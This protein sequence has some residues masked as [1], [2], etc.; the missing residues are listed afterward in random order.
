MGKGINIKLS[1]VVVG[2][3]E[4]TMNLEYK[5]TT[6]EMAKNIEDGLAELVKQLNNG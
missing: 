1:L 5:N 4:V 3:E 6:V 2:E